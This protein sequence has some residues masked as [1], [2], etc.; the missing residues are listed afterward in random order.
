MRM[1]PFQ[2]RFSLSML[3]DKVVFFCLGP[4]LPS[5]PDE[6]SHEV[7]AEPWPKAPSHGY[8]RDWTSSGRWKQHGTLQF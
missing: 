6:K 3:P 5:R 8:F 1:R 7:H 4:D 2:H